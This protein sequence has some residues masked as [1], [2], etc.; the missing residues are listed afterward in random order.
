MQLLSS[1]SSRI[2]LQECCWK[3]GT[4]MFTR[5]FFTLRPCYQRTSVGPPRFTFLSTSGTTVWRVR[6]RLCALQLRQFIYRPTAFNLSV[7]LDLK[8]GQR[9]SFSSTLFTPVSA[10]HPLASRNLFQRIISY[11]TVRSDK[12]VIRRI[13]GSR[14]TAT[15]FV[16]FRPHSI[17]VCDG[18][19]GLDSHCR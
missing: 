7:W 17:D 15:S 10:V 4:V 6:N 11:T 13:P 3:S 16:L 2:Y 12:I 9:I 1:F 14:T 18:T 19:A 5:W 8:I